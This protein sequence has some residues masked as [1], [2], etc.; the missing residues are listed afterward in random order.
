MAFAVNGV[1]FFETGALR[2]WNNNQNWRENA[3]IA[4]V[5]V[6]QCNG[7]PEGRGMYH[8]HANPVCLYK[9]T[10]GQHSPIIGF[11][12]DGFP[13]YGT[14]GFA[15][16]NG[17]G[18]V[19]VMHTSYQL[20]QGTRPA[21]PQG[22]GGNYDGRYMQDYDFVQGLGDLDQCNGRF[23]VTPEYPQGI[24]HYHVTIDDKNQPAFPYIINCYKGTPDPY[25][26]RV[27]R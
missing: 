3:V 26:F 22:P 7:H 18:S 5:G 24:Y 9:E 10:E 20:K 17:T 11:A 2:Y 4:E 23:A 16:T 19:R 6:D 27:G 25:N 13:I 8:Y 21:P 1:T 14:R 15:N 12:F